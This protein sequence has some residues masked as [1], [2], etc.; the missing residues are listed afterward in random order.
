M[1]GK[2]ECIIQSQIRLTGAICLNHI[3][4]TDMRVLPNEHGY[5]RIY[6]LVDRNILERIERADL[7]QPVKILAEDKVLFCGVVQNAGWRFEGQAI[8]L[9]LEIS[10]L[11]VLLDGRKKKKSF[12]NSR[13]TFGSIIKNVINGEHSGEVSVYAED[14]EIE[15]PVYQFQETDWQFIRRMAAGLG[16]CVYPDVTEG[17][18]SIKIG[19]KNTA[20]TITLESA[21]YDCGVSG[22]FF[23]EEKLYAMADKSLFVFYRIESYENLEIGQKVLF[24]NRNMRILEKRMFLKGAE[25]I[26]QYKLGN[27][28]S[29]YLNRYSN[30]LLSGTAIS[31]KVLDTKKQLL[32]IH[33]DMDE[34]QKEEEAYWYEW[35]PETGNIMYCM[36]QK[37]TRVQLYFP[38]E[39]EASAIAISCI[40]ENGGECSHM[41]NTDNKYFANESGKQFCLKQSELGFMN[42]SKENSL[43][44]DDKTGIKIT[45]KQEI[46]MISGEK[47]EWKAKKIVLNTPVEI[48]M[49]RG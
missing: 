10:S 18:L 9:E 28:K 24:R 41:S 43:I 20:Q 14:F 27:E 30:P 26:F 7:N 11:S 12:Q 2:T 19:M 23:S 8:H 49:I 47:I 45:G 34:Y 3:R 15:A 1:T 17:N 21:D 29:C 5:A 44:E 46:T 6:A 38:S 48:K 13:I 31:G 39:E 35:V 32:K 25:L 22:D 40:R 42:D 4:Y 33:L 37:G 36:P 16:S